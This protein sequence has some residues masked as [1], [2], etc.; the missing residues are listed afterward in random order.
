MNKLVITPKDK[1][2]IKKKQEILGSKSR[3]K[4]ISFVLN[5]ATAVDSDIYQTTRFNW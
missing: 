5:I 1:S 2:A 3:I 4:S